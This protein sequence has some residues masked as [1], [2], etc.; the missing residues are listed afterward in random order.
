MWRVKNGVLRGIPVPTLA[1]MRGFAR[2]AN[3][4]GYREE[5]DEV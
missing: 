3:L 2:G 1:E 5:E 4:E